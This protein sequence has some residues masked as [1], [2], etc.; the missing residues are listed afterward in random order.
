MLVFRAAIDTSRMTTMT[1]AK[2]VAFR[3]IWERFWE[4]KQLYHHIVTEPA[5]S[6]RARTANILSLVENSRF[7]RFTGVSKTMVT[8]ANKLQA[9]KNSTESDRTLK[10]LQLFL[11]WLANT[12][13]DSTVSATRIVTW[14]THWIMRNLLPL[15]RNS[16]HIC[17]RNMLKYSSP[18]NEILSGHEENWLGTLSQISSELKTTK[19]IYD[20]LKLNTSEQ[21]NVSK[22]HS[23]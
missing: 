15:W 4:E 23:K 3:V 16:L 22:Q 5:V 9:W 12:F 18:R 8:I 19:K 20:K 14:Q 11:R 17:T 7:P 21:A 10:I 1:E 13:H 2:T 6:P